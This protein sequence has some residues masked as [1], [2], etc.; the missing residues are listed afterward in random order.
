MTIYMTKKPGSVPHTKGECNIK[1]LAYIAI[2]FLACLILTSNLSHARH[3]GGISMKA[4]AVLL[5]AAQVGIVYGLVQ[6][7]FPV[8]VYKGDWVFY[9]FVFTTTL[10]ASF[11][12]SLAHKWN[13]PPIG[14][15]STA[16][17]LE[18]VFE[19]LYWVAQIFSIQTVM[20]WMRRMV[21]QYE[22][23]DS[24]LPYFVSIFFT[25][26]KQDSGSWKLT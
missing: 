14:K 13:D 2:E 6:K 1:F 23:S 10:F 20:L 19:V 9:P 26:L 18:L 22:E 7:P 8:G 5:F 11:A 21:F 4:I 24:A 12:L 16:E 15:L 25:T 17:H 3:I